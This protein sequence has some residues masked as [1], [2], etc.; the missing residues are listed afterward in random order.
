MRFRQEY[1]GAHRVATEVGDNLEIR[2]EC[3]RYSKTYSFNS[4]EVSKLKEESSPS[5]L[6]H[7]RISQEL[8]NVIWNARLGS[9]KSLQMHTVMQ[10][11]M[12]VGPKGASW[13]ELLLLS[14]SFDRDLR[15]DGLA[16]QINVPCRCWLL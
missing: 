1:S 2:Q 16:G 14:S 9:R 12:C 8:M 15:W 7:Y 5:H 4:L 11:Q 13:G 6:F 10:M 3:K